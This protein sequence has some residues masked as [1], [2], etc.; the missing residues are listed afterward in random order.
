MYLEPN[1]KTNDLREEIEFMKIF[2]QKAN[3][4]FRSFKNKFLS[5][6]LGTKGF[7]TKS[8]NADCMI[9]KHKRKLM[10]ENNALWYPTLFDARSMRLN[11]MIINT[12]NTL[13]HLSANMYN[14]KIIWPEICI[15][16]K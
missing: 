6:Y 11:E 12:F 1:M 7:L 16:S 15:I 10:S 14:F 2:K 13:F 3:N 5:L 8:V 9:L 4:T